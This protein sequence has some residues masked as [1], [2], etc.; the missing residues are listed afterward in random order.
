MSPFTKRFV[1]IAFILGS[2]ALLSAK[3]EEEETLSKEQIIKIV[4]DRLFE[5]TPD[6][7]IDIS[8]SIEFC[9]VDTFFQ[10]GFRSWLTPKNKIPLSVDS[11]IIDGAGLVSHKGFFPLADTAA[12][13]ISTEKCRK[14]MQLLAYPHYLAKKQFAGYIL[15]CQKSKTEINGIK[16]YKINIKPNPD[17]NDERYPISG[18]LFIADAKPYRILRFEHTL[19]KS[20]IQQSVRWDFK[21]FAL[22]DFPYK[23]TC[24]TETAMCGFALESSVKVYLVS[25]LFS[26]IADSNPKTNQ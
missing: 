15:N 6:Q 25:A 19:D 1:I 2:I 26:A 12:N 7:K 23:M 9:L 4:G 21:E 24:A 11:L 8:G 17:D 20:E 13:N 10:V 18:Y 16:C 5:N 22:K 14:I 3:K